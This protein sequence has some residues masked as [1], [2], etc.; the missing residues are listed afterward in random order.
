MTIKR[1]DLAGALAQ[2]K[3]ARE[4]SNRKLAALKKRQ[5]ELQTASLVNW[6]DKLAMFKNDSTEFK[7]AEMD[8]PST[9]QLVKI[10]VPKTTVSVTGTDSK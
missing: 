4:D 6:S 7:A 5:A 10:S 1:T 9:P 2:A 3:A 8:I